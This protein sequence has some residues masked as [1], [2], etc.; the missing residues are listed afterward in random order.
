MSVVFLSLLKQTALENLENLIL[1]IFKEKLNIPRPVG[2]FF[3][4]TV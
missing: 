2:S 4:K 3:Q 1:S